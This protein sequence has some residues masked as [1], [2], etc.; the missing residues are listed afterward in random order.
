MTLSAQITADLS[1]VFFNSD[2]F[3]TAATLT[4]LGVSSTIYV[5]FDEE[6]VP[7]SPYETDVEAATPAALAVSTDVAE[8]ENGDV[9]IIGNETFYV[10]NMQKNPPGGGPGTTLLILSRG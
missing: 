7:Y 9:L 4:H 6:Y 8:A 1:A 10:M 5:I 3:A 2:D